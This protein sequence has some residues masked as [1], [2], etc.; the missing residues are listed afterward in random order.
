M[1]HRSLGAQRSFEACHHE[2]GANALAGNVSD[3]DSEPAFG[4][5]EKI[6][7]VS[8]YLSRRPAA[9]AIVQARHRGKALRKEVLLDFLR[10]FQLAIQPL[11]LR[12]LPADGSRQPGDLLRQSRLSRRPC[13]KTVES[14]RDSAMGELVRF[15]FLPCNEVGGEA[16][17]VSMVP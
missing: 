13:V 15:N 12:H 8:A 3:S 16:L 11:A 5:L 1:A 14:A 2:R 6:I 7:V 17:L 10:D 4:Q 9:P